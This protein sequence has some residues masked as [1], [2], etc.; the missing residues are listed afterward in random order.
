MPH[1]V[2]FGDFSWIMLLPSILSIGLAGNQLIFEKLFNIKIKNQ[3]FIFAANNSLAKISMI[4]LNIISKRRERKTAKPLFSRLEQEYIR[5]SNQSSFH[6]IKNTLSK[7][8]VIFFILLCSIFHYWYFI[9]HLIFRF[10]ANFVLAEVNPQEVKSKYYGIL[11]IFFQILVLTPLNRIVFKY[12][13]YRHQQLA[14]GMAILGTCLYLLDMFREGGDYGMFFFLSGTVLNCIEI[15]IEKY[16]MENKYITI[17][18]ILFYEGCTEFCIN[19]LLFGIGFFFFRKDNSIFLFSIE[20]QNFSQLMNS[21]DENGILCIVEL[22]VHYLVEVII[23]LSMMMTLYYLNP[24]YSYVSEISSIFF[25]WIRE[26]IKMGPD[27]FMNT[28]WPLS[29]LGY[30]TILLGAFIYN[31]IIILYFCGLHR[32]TKK[33]LQKRA[34]NG[35]EEIDLIKILNDHLVSESSCASDL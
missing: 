8:T 31:E 16:L 18:E 17:F 25:I 13:I 21:F 1:F 15:V 26:M 12:S 2:T 33:E 4:V 5:Q 9:S 32:N 6:S 24:N 28:Y 11:I 20:V 34:G 7:I 30:F 19:I 14:L 10:F 23:V 27:V 3:L 22:L 35:D 29:I